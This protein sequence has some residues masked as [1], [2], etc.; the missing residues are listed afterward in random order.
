MFTNYENITQNKLNEIKRKGFYRNYPIISQI[1][2]NPPYGINS[3]TDELVTIFGNNNYL[4]LSNNKEIIEAK[5]NAIK[6]YGAG[7]SGTRNILGTSKPLVDLEN[8]ISKW[9]NKESSLVFISALDAN[10]GTLAALGRNLENTIFLSDQKNHASIIDG[11]KLSGSS[12]YIFKHNNLEDLE[13]KLKEIRSAS[14][15]RAIII[16]VESLY[17]MD[18]DFSPIEKITKL[19]NKYNALLFVD[20]VHANGL[21]GKKGAGYIEQLGLSKQVDI[22]CGTF[23]KAMG[24]SGGF[25]STSENM[26]EFIR[27]E[28]RNFIFTT[29]PAPDVA[30]A[31]NASLR[32]VSSEEGELLRSKLFK[33]VADLKIKLKKAKIEYL[34]NNS[35]IIP[36]IFGDEKK[37]SLI[38]KSLMEEYKFAVTPIFYPTV[39]AGKARIRINVTPNHTEE[40]ISELVVAIKFL[41]KKYEHLRTKDIAENDNLCDKYNIKNKLK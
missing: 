12:K 14:D 20:E 35:Q 38:A 24:V 7:S 11:I 34:D 41:V 25:I 5:I 29:S 31:C 18:G 40:M 28:A 37:T 33:N 15:S 17:S 30:E 26:A 2:D 4:G 22:I 9:Q 32:V 1:A 6:T 21:Y 16:V 10:I 3:K 23:A 27:H 19:K 39:E 36:I 13:N 8:N